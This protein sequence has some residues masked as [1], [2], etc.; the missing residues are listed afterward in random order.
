[1][2]VLLALLAVQSVFALDNG[3]GLSLRF[4]SDL[5]HRSSYSADGLVVLGSISVV[6]CLFSHP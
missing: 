6:D 3:V 4:L 1:M 5:K 2:I